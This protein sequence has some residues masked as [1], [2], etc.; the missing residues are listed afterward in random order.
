MARSYQ[1]HELSR[2]HCVDFLNRLR[3][4]R[5]LV[6]ANAESFHEAAAVLE[7]IGQTMRGKIENGLG[8][9]QAE[10]IAL[11]KTANGAVEEEV[12]RQFNVVREARNDAVHGGDYIRH[13]SSRL[14]DFLLL[15]EDAVKTKLYRVKDL[16]VRNP[17]SVEPW[18]SVAH[19]RKE[20][21]ANSFSTIPVLLPGIGWSIL[22]DLAIMKFLRDARADSLRRTR[23]SMQVDEAIGKGLQHE[24][25]VCR[26]C[27]DLVDDFYEN[28]KSPLLV[29]ERHGEEE[30]LIG[31]VSPFDLL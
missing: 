20:M 12:V 5:T 19:V 11:A 4:A 14:V 2:D 22:T 7:Y 3:A 23:L 25:A 26:R 30:R 13:L 29:T 17:V 10:L 9:Y 16:M 18:Q 28:L 15:L 8:H 1:P 24:V 31:L 27:D 6:L 21:L